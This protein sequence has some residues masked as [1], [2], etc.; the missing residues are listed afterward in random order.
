VG[1]SDS[2][3]H[4]L[5]RGGVP[6]S[7]LA[8]QTGGATPMFSLK[9]KTA[10]VTGAAAGIGA[11]IAQTLAEA[12]AT[13]WVADLDEKSG[14]A[15]ASGIAAAGGRARFVRLDITR[16]GEIAAAVAAVHGRSTSS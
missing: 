7:W 15:V 14:A 6:A 8:A 10:L 4:G 1:L 11:A 12:G 9:N 13:V 5:R 2:F 16:E 3:F